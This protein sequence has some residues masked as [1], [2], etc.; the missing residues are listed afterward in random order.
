MTNSPKH[1]SAIG[2]VHSSGK[3][4]HATACLIS[5]VVGLLIIGLTNF[6]VNPFAN[7][8][9]T[10]IRPLVQQSRPAKVELLESQNPAPD[11]LILGSS[12]VLTLKP[13]QIEAVTRTRFL[14][15]GVNSGAAEDF[16]AFIGLYQEQF[17]RY[18]KQI[19]IGLDIQSF[20]VNRPI[21]ARF[22][23]NQA[24]R[25]FAAEYIGWSDILEQYKGILSDSQLI[26]SLRSLTHWI[27][28]K[29]PASK[30]SWNEDG[31][32]AYLSIE[33]SLQ[34]GAFDLEKEIAKTKHRHL[35]RFSQFDRLSEPRLKIIDKILQLAERENIE[36]FLFISPLHP[37]LLQ[38]LRVHTKYDERKQQLL[39]RLSVMESRYGFSCLDLSEISSFGGTPDGF[40]DGIHYVEPNSSKIIAKLLAVTP[41]N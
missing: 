14:N 28:G 13:S 33:K 30:T 37:E 35:G 40:I 20:S 2:D 6:I 3:R 16:I 19:V 17:G 31:T 26:S 21:D 38:E 22:L 32:I 4:Q 10:Y 1:S 34:N 7:Y 41:E 18:P 5:C 36:L 39:E 11:G 15:L 25:P 29:Y 8:P 24:L 12:R 27:S 23:S 9:P